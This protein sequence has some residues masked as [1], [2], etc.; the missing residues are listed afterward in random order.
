M[1]DFME[2]QVTEKD[3]ECGKRWSRTECPIAIAITRVIKELL[4]EDDNIVLVRKKT[5]RIEERV[6]A[7]DGKVWAWRLIK[8]PIKAQEFVYKFDRKQKVGPMTL[9]LEI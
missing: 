9:E 3:I 4:P 1:S 5:V 2:V 6:I 8:L 7:K